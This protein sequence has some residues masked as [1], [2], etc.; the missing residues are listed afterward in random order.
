MSHSELII[1]LKFIIVSG[2]ILTAL[3]GLATIFDAFEAKRRKRMSDEFNEFIART[4]ARAKIDHE[5]AEP[6][7]AP[8]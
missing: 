6:P 3:L 2:F 1:V 8:R 4:D 7:R 5:A